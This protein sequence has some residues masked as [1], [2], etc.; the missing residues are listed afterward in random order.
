M[1]REGD[2]VARDSQFER[3]LS[4]YT[5]FD[6]INDSKQRKQWYD[7]VAIAYQWA[8]PS[9]SQ[10][11]IDQALMQ[12]CFR[13]CAPQDFSL[14]EIGC[15]P[16][17]ATIDFAKYGI[18]IIAMD[19]S[20]AACQVACE[21][22]GAYEHVEIVEST[23]EDYEL[24]AQAGS[25]DVVLAATSFHWIDPA[26]AVRKAAQAL[27]PDG[28]LILLWAT[29]PQPSKAVSDALQPI[30]EK[31]HQQKLGQDLYESRAQYQKNF[32]LFADKIYQAGFFARTPLD[33]D[34]IHGRYGIEQYLAL[35]STLSGYIQLP[36][37]QRT[38]L[39]QEIGQELKAL[40]HSEF[41]TT[42]WMA[43]QVAPLR[44]DLPR[45]LET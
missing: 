39:L 35:L 20:P 32:E 27:K 30:F 3:D 15:G 22:C 10:E 45:T 34:T 19:P 18:N 29:P 21:V 7:S 11:M 12:T 13:D 36:S 14:L 41:P 9:Y 2:D 31:H 26:I 17:K 8:R 25:F 43:A 44:A 4:W 23:F 38:A 40:G 33:M 6:Q 28:S 1:G 24:G 37:A 42:H 5:L 16:A